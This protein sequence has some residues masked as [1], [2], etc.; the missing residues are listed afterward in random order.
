M[1]KKHPYSGR[2]GCAGRWD[3]HRWLVSARPLRRPA[4]GEDGGLV[5]AQ[6]RQERR[7]RS[8][9]EFEVPPWQKPKKQKFQLGV[10]DILITAFGI[11]LG[12][13]VGLAIF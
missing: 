5:L 12:A 7:L 11:G 2:S 4:T 9:D 8:L 10:T 6:P 1:G 13:F 3:R